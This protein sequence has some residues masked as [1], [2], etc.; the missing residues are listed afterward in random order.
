MKILFATK[1]IGGTR[2]VVALA[3]EAKKRGHEIYVVAEGKGIPQWNAAG[4]TP[5]IIGSD[6][7][8]TNPWMLDVE[9][10]FAD[11]RP[12]VVVCGQSSPINYED[13]IGIRANMLGV[14]LI[15]A[16]DFWAGVRR[17]KAIPDLLLV[18]DEVDARL[19]EDTLAERSGKI[20]GFNI[21]IVG[22]A[23]Y[24]STSHVS[25]GVKTA[26]ADL[27]KRF[28]MIFMYAGASPEPTTA[29][30]TL[31]I[32][33]LEKTYGN[34]C[35]IPRFHPKYAGATRGKSDRPYSELWED[36]LLH[37]GDRIVSVPEAESSD[38]L[39]GFCDLTLS[40]FSLSSIPA[41]VAAKPVVS[42]WTPETRA[43]LLAQSNLDE[44]PLSELGC[45]V[46]IESSVP[47]NG[48][49]PAPFENR[50][51]LKPFDAKLAFD[52]IEK[53]V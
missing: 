1:D 47:L 35:L 23:S 33:C 4:I 36:M 8:I 25:E 24:P 40:G 17:T 39:A 27:H 28:D 44:F 6:D 22:N 18:L 51:K 2:P 38:Q 37:F 12:D 43:S 3:F 21:V 31:L 52:A 14:P 46:K 34:W 49:D 50:A 20:S 32:G 7:P 5:N 45:A 42:L 11:V 13:V 16:T 48:I 29:E 41:V 19:A 10:L 30:L 26:M 15:S 53:L 9:E